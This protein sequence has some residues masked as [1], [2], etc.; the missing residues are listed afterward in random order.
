MIL[1]YNVSRKGG[2]QWKESLFTRSGFL[3]V[4]IHVT[5]ELMDSP[6]LFNRSTRPITKRTIRYALP[7]IATSILPDAAL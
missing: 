1:W 4:T 2:K 3:N 6:S 7:C 5:L